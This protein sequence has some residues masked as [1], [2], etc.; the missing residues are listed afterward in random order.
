MFRTFGRQTFKRMKNLVFFT[1][2]AVLVRQIA[3]ELPPGVEKSVNFTTIDSKVGSG[4]V[5]VVGDVNSDGDSDGLPQDFAGQLLRL[6]LKS[7][8]FLPPSQKA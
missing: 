8:H 6:N 7:K 5:G 2:A 3:C 4:D 1:F